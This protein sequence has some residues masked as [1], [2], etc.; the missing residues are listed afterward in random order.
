MRVG[1]APL[2]TDLLMLITASA[3]LAQ[4][5]PEALGAVGV[6]GG[7][8]VIL[9]GLSTLRQSGRPPDEQ[10]GG[11]TSRPWKD[12]LKG[13]TVNLLNP[14]AWLFWM[15][16]GG[17]AIAAAW[18]SSPYQ[19]VLFFCIFEACLVGSKAGLAGIVAGNRRRLQGRGYR[20]TL[21]ALGLVL[22]LFGGQ[23]IWQGF[24]R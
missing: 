12:L 22:L 9:I 1:I 23:L 5:G 18:A 6:L 21:R 7:I 15:V 24:S 14:H 17:P 2:L 20:W 19:A 3:L 13:A 4:L 10:G 11:T 8:V 16:V